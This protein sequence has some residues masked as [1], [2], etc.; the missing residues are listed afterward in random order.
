MNTKSLTQYQPSIHRLGVLVSHEDGPAVEMQVL[1]NNDL[2]SRVRIDRIVEWPGGW[3]EVLTG[4]TVAPPEEPED[5]RTLA[6]IRV[7]AGA[8]VL[9]ESDIG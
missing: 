9:T 8:V 4:S 1:P 5:S 6:L 7:P 3:V 2:E